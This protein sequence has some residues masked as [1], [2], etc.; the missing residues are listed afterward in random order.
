MGIFPSAL[1][2]AVSLL[3]NTS[4]D[5]SNANLETSQLWLQRKSKMIPSSIQKRLNFYTFACTG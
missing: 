2:Q 5:D 3:S 4:A 1:I